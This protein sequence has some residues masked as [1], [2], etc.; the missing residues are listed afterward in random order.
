MADVNQ[1]PQGNRGQAKR[2]GAFGHYHLLLTRDPTLPSGPGAGRS[3]VD[4]WAQ[5]YDPSQVG[6]HRA[7][8]G[9]AHPP[10]RARTPRSKGPAR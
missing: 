6:F 4:H 8:P 1:I 2:S 7:Q 5:A 9:Q 10:R 3:Q